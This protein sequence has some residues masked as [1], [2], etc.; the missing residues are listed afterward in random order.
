MASEKKAVD[1]YANLAAVHPV[2]AV[3]GTAKF[4]KFAFPYSI[5][6]K[7]GILVCR[8]EYL[9]LSLAQLNSSGDSLECCLSIDDGIADFQDYTNPA[10]VDSAY[11]A[12]YDLGAAATGNFVISPIVR[13]FSQLPG[14]GILVAPNPLYGG[15]KSSGAGGVMGCWVRLWYTYMTLATDEYWQLVES[16]RIITS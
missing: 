3:V 15:V 11:I 16:R 9:F 5:M 7:I 2:E 4:E 13:D 10:M 12:R 14:G 8:I 1:R 6:D